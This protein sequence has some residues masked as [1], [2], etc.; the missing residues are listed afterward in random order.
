MC[1]VGYGSSSVILA[2]QNYWDPISPML[3]MSSCFN[4]V[5][6]NTFVC[7]VVSGS[8]FDLTT[9]PYHV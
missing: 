1:S 5:L 2:N 9:L 8:V 4:G 3:V 6:M 7:A